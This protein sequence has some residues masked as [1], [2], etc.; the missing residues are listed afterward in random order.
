MEVTHGLA[1][2]FFLISST[3]YGFWRTLKPFVPFPDHTHMRTTVVFNIPLAMKISQEG[4]G[5]GGHYNFYSH[6]LHNGMLPQY[7]FT[8]YAR[9][10]G[11]LELTGKLKLFL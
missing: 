2:F 3:G 10:Q 1:S 6:T 4:E 7:V 5:I 11:I 9:T 8:W